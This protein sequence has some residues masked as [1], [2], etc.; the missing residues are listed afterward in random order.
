V[1]EYFKIEMKKIY[2]FALLFF[3]S[4][5]NNTE[6]KEAKNETKTVITNCYLAAFNRDTTFLKITDSASALSGELNYLPYEKDGSIGVLKSISINGDTLFGIYE[7]EQEGIQN[8]CEMAMLKKDNNY[9]LTNDIW[10][11][12]N[13]VYDST[14][15]R[16]KFISRNKITFTGDTLHLTN[17]CN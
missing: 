1:L 13:Y 7:Y 9:I 16:G 10:G 3:C 17:N 12:D 5:K 8:I 14:Q 6:K 15:T 4:C 11:S 2:P